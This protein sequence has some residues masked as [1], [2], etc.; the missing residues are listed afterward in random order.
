[1]AALE[2]IPMST[3]NVLEALTSSH[4][5]PKGWQTVRFDQMAESITDRVDNPAEADVSYYVGLEH[6]DP[7]SLHIR[8]WGVPTDVEATKLR[9][10]PGDIIFGRRRAYQRKLAVAEFE[11]I[12]SAHALVLRA[13][14]E[15]VL[16]EFLPFL[17][18][19]DAFFERAMSISVGSLS[20]TIN[21]KTLARQEFVLP[22]KDEQRRIAEILWAADEAIVSWQNTIRQ[23]EDAKSTYRHSIFDD[24]K[25]WKTATVDDL[26]EVQLGK[27]LSPQARHGHSPKPYLGNSNVQWGRFDLTDVKEMDFDEEEFSKFSLKQGDLLVCE[28]GEV[29]RSAI[30]QG[31]IADCCFQKAV[32]RLRPTSNQLLPEIMLQFMFYAASSGVFAGLTGHSTIAHLTA[33]KLRTLKVTV[34]PMDVQAKMTNAFS[35]F[36]ASIQFLQDHTTANK[37]LKRDLLRHLLGH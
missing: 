19:S 7:E 11:G 33:V 2:S 3:S 16:K 20:P 4:A 21:W 6:L 30:W 25:Y 35:G 9:F 28:G 31:E 24:C 15:T 36:E 5:L 10:Q 17:M 27:M 12:C 29:G 37:M 26:F 34:P 32:H 14:E 22:P 18:Q 13:R 8:R 1:M 23:I